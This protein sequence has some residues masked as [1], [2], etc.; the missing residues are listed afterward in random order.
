MY[1]LIFPYIIYLVKST[2]VCLGYSQPQNIIF[3]RL[4][5][6]LGKKLWSCSHMQQP[7]L[8]LYKVICGGLLLKRS[9][10]WWL[11]GNNLA[12]LPPDLTLK[13]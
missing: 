3:S 6:G 10:N 8:S 13:C 4:C 9:V 11:V 5:C 12:F 2:N 1:S 7:L